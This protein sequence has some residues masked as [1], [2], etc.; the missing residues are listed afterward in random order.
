MTSE[1]NNILPV[2]T[3]GKV[4]VKFMSNAKFVD[5]IKNLPPS[6]RSFHPTLKVWPIDLLALPDLLEHLLL[7]G[8]APSCDKVKASCASCRAIAKSMYTAQKCRQAI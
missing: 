7:L 6:Q 3:L 2:E 8:Y 5:A 1:S 4:H